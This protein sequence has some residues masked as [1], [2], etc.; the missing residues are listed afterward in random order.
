MQT[1]LSQLKIAQK[2]GWD[3]IWLR[4]PGPMLAA[5]QLNSNMQSSKSI[6]ETGL[7][8]TK[9]PSPAVPVFPTF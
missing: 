3:A 5:L 2:K 9:C 6:K 1:W 8:Y 7:G 4:H